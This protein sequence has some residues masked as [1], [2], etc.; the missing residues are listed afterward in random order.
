M[1]DRKIQSDKGMVRDVFLNWRFHLNVSVSKYLDLGT[2]KKTHVLFAYLFI[3]VVSCL[4]IFFVSLRISPLLLI[5]PPLLISP[6]LLFL[7]S[8]LAGCGRGTM[9]EA[10]GLLLR[11]DDEAVFGID[12]LRHEG[13]LQFVL[14]AC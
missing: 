1:V 14:F 5:S 8:H 11:L 12:V 4:L 13:T 9:T 2:M 6:L 3:V 10:I 7:L